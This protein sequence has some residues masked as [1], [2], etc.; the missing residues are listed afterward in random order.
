M[1]KMFCSDVLP[2]IPAHAGGVMS[3][4]GRIGARAAVRLFVLAA[5]FAGGGTLKAEVVEYWAPGV[6]EQG[7][8]Y[9]TFQSRNTCWAGCSADI[10]VWWQDRIR[11]KYDASGMTKIWK[12]EDLFQVYDTGANGYFNTGGDYVWKALEWAMA[13]TCPTVHLKTP[14]NYQYYHTEGDERTMLYVSG[15]LNSEREKVE[16]AILGGFQQGNRIAALT[17][18]NHAWTLYGVGYDTV[19]KE[20]THIWATDPYPD[21]L[22]KPERKLHKFQAVRSNYQGGDWLFFQRG[23]YDPENNAWNQQLIEPAEVTFLSVDDK[24]LVDKDGK[25]AFTPLAPGPVPSPDPKP[26]PTPEHA[27]IG[28]VKVVGATVELVG[29]IGRDSDYTYELVS[30]T[31]P[32][33]PGASWQT[34]DVAPETTPDGRVVFRH[35]PA[36]GEKVRF[37]RLRVSRP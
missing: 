37:Y 23:I 11:E 28:A 18:R 19:K 36:E 24:Y 30:S 21:N 1:K 33:T 13:N 12:N 5:A 22:K 17:S 14:G 31:D 20:I 15:Y 10:F 9:N 4:P 7:G 16:K 3:R 27:E 35:T 26:E 6:S 34:L 25:P 29:R 8:W 32:A 2:R